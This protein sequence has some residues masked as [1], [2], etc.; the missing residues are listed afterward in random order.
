MRRF[1]WKTVCIAIGIL[2]ATS[3]LFAQSGDKIVQRSDKQILDEKLPEAEFDI[4]KMDEGEL[5][6]FVGVV[7]DCRYS[8][9]L[10]GTHFR[11][12]CNSARQKY[13]VE[14]SRDRAVDYVLNMLDVACER[15]LTAE[16]ASI[17]SIDA[18]RQDESRRT[19]RLEEIRKAVEA[20]NSNS[21]P[22]AIS[23]IVAAEIRLLKTAGES[24]K[25]KRRPQ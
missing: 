10:A 3:P 6:A 21:P 17:T 19:I 13:R 18:N 22:S 7:T 15:N 23:I 12:V 2:F 4:M 16:T 1:T 8:T 5:R 14:Y 9:L 25:A 11:M 20:A 24:F